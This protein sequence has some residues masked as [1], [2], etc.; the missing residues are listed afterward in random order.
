MITWRWIISHRCSWMAVYVL[1][2]NAQSGL[3]GVKMISICMYCFLGVCQLPRCN[4][5]TQHVIYLRRATS[6]ELWIPVLFLYI[7]SIN[8]L[9]LC[10][11]FLQTFTS[12]HSI[13]LILCFPQNTVRLTTSSQVGDKVLWLCCAGLHVA[14]S[15]GS[16]PCQGSAS[17]TFGVFPCSYWFD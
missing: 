14:T 13:R 9:L 6:S 11:Y 5:F 17:N 16:A 2:C 4:L 7:Q 3:K 15:I 10:V 8:C 12:F 1:C